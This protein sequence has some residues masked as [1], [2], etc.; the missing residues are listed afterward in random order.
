VTTYLTAGVVAVL[1]AQSVCLWRA[2]SRLSAIER[3]ESRLSA[4]AHTIVLLTD[5]TETGLKDLAARLAAETPA[6]P[7]GAGRQRRVVGAARRGR[8]VADIA[9]AEELAESEVR[10]RLSL[11][12]GP[13]THSGEEARGQT[14]AARIAKSEEVAAWQAATTSR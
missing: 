9:A 2:L 3:F 6:R 1:I 12:Q 10:L 5:A 7:S 11:A 4:L 8:S 13:T 14:A